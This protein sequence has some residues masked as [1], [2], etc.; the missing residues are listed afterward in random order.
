M[1]RAKRGGN[2]DFWNISSFAVMALIGFFTV[3]LW[4]ENTGCDSTF[5]LQPM[6]Q[7]LVEGTNPKAD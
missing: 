6:A 1:E 7:V 4:S 3:F 5:N 2:T